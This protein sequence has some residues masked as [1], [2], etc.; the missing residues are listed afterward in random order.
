M[1]EM[2]RVSTNANVGR[3]QFGGFLRRIVNDAS[4]AARALCILIKEGLFQIQTQ[5][6][7]VKQL[8]TQFNDFVVVCFTSDS[9]LRVTLGPIVEIGISGPLFLGDAK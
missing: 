7:E 3:I 4:N 1:L 8:A 5:G 9:D 6:E 2:Y